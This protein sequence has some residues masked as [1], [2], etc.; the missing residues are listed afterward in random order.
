MAKILYVEDNDD[1]VYMLT[2]RL[3]RRGFEVIVASDGEQGIALACAEAP[4][5]ILMDLGL[6][7]LN[8]WEAS[9]RLKAAPETRSI[10]IIALSAHA[11]AS[12]RETAI[13]AGCDDFDSKPI[14]FGRL[15]DK[16]RALLPEAT[17]L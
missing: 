16:I 5:L 17:P 8:G 2:A 7:I 10:P 13:A 9:R 11:M 6:P 1:N 4:A 14:E 12:D 3:R 15:L